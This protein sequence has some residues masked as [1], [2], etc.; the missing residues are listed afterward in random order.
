MSRF[1]V[2]YHDAELCPGC[3]R[4]GNQL[5]RRTEEWM[6]LMR[7]G[8]ELRERLRQAEDRIVKLEAQLRQPAHQRGQ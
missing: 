7:K 1:D 5:D 4:L 8:S 3:T 6:G 2:L